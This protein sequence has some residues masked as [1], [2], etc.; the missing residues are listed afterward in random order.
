MT[1]MPP[2]NHLVRPLLIVVMLVLAL[3]PGVHAA[4]APP[5]VVETWNIRYDNPGDGPHAWRHRREGVIEHL[6]DTGADVIGLQEVLPRQLA[7]IRAGLDGYDAFSRGREREAD[8]GE[9]VPI[10][11]RRDH[12]RLDADH[13]THFWLSETPEVPGSMSWKTACTRMVTMI[14]LVP[15]EPTS[16]RSPI[17]VCN[18]HLDHQSADA[19]ANGAA[20]VRERIASRPEEMRG[21]PVVILGDFNATPGSPPVETLLAAGDDGAFVDAWAAGGER[22]GVEDGDPA[23]ERPSGTWNGW[24]ANA[25]AGR[26][27]FVLVRGMDVVNAEI[28]HPTHDA[29]PL[30]DHW[31]VRATLA[32]PTTATKTTD[33]SS[34]SAE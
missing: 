5:I 4:A 25:R 31:P 11:W 16:G 32:M 12:W 14:R 18:L 27:D 3:T 13:A 29:G 20:L 1:A 21:E 8:R 33:A 6:R 2:I 22:E 17:W 23:R 19:R 24:D 34:V 7:A 9:A 30:S 28:L 26:I 10:L 15:V